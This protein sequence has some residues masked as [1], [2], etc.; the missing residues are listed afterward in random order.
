[1]KAVQILSALFAVC[2]AINWGTNCFDEQLDAATGLL[3]ANCD[4][5]DGQGTLKAAS[6]NLNTCYGFA[7]QKLAVGFILQ[8]FPPSLP[9]TI[10]ADLCDVAAHPPRQ[11]WRLVHGLQSISAGPPPPDLPEV[12]VAELHLWRPRGGCLSGHW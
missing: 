1:M 4:A 10:K 6:I 5:G 8:H 12:G 7:D 11:L 3:T 2:S 9:T